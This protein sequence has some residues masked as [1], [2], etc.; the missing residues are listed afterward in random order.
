[1][2]LKYIRHNQPSGNYCRGTLYSAHF[3]PN[4]KGGY[5]ECLTFISDAYEMPYGDTFPL[6]LIYPFGVMRVNGHLRIALGTGDRRSL[7]HL[8]N[9]GARERLYEEMLGV[10][11][12]RHECRVE[13]SEAQ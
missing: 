13:V 6:P 1:M 9:R 8:I 3:Q 5:N 7:L 12:E 11:R 4:E 2:Y 10:L